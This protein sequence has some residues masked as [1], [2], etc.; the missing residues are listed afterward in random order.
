MSVNGKS[1]I[2]GRAAWIV[3][4]TGPNSRVGSGYG[5]TLTRTVATGLTTRKTRTIGHGPVLPPKTRHL[6]STILAPIRN[7][8][9]DR[10]MTWSVWR[11]CS[12]SRSFT[13]RCQICDWTNIRCVAIENPPISRKISRY[14]TA[15][16]R[17]LV[18]SQIWQR[19]V[20]ARLKLHNLRT[21]HVLIRSVLKYLLGPNVAGTVK[22][23]CGPDTTQL[24]NRRFISGA[25]NSPAKKRRFG[26]LAGSGTEPNRTASQNPDHWQ[27]HPDPLRTLILDYQTAM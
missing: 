15:I 5:S 9:S 23:N 8:S 26:F 21:D 7:L 24:K 18:R 2:F 12:F 19:E 16:L 25:G 1:T 27:V 14:F 22:W 3:S 11:L 4:A 13:S 20:I 6:K 10:N 17:I